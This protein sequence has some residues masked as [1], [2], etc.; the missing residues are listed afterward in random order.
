MIFELK[1]T[2]ACGAEITLKFEEVGLPEVLQHIGNFLQ[3]SGFVFGER[4]LE[5]VA[6]ENDL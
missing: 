3:G 2:D 1:C 5:L 6:W 4:S